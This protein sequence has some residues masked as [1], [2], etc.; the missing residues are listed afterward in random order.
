MYLIV[1]SNPD[2]AQ[3]LL[4]TNRPINIGDKIEGTYEQL[5]AIA[6]MN[7]DVFEF[8]GL[9]KK[10]VKKNTRRKHGPKKNKLMK[11]GDKFKSK[12]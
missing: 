3:K 12:D 5:S 1:I 9:E 2:K 6:I 8:H 11:K 4:K 10:T 7:K